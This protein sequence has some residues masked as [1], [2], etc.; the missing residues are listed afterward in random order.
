MLNVE[1]P[2]T[3]VGVRG[4]APSGEKL[5]E[6]SKKSILYAVRERYGAT[7]KGDEGVSGESSSTITKESTTKQDAE[8][9][10]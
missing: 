7:G 4:R 9:T 5:R 8:S 3:K 2:G 1:R 10:Y 6:V